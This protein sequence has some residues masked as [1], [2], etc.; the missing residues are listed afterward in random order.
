MKE[1]LLRCNR[2]LLALPCCHTDGRECNCYNCLK[3][4]FWNVSDTYDCEKKVNYYVL[5]YGPSFESEIYHYLAF[6]QVLEEFES[7]RKLKILSLGCG[8]A[9][10]LL[11][12]TTYIQDKGLKVKFEYC[13]VDQNNSWNKARYLTENAIFNNKDVSSLIILYGFDLIERIPRSSTPGLYYQDERTHP[14]K[15]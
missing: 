4:N 3:N 7:K 6:T 2:N 15:T 10:D 12:I 8:F 13:G 9:P 14:E 11:A 5:N 1:L